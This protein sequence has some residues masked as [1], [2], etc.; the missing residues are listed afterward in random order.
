MQNDLLMHSETGKKNKIME[1]LEQ[2][3]DSKVKYAEKTSQH[4]L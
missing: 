1:D 2:Q 4:N 3:H